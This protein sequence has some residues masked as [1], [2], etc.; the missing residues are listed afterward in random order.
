LNKKQLQQRL[1]RNTKKLD[2]NPK[3]LKCAEKKVTATQKKLL[4]TKEHCK[5][6]ASLALERRK[7]VRL[8]SLNA[9]IKEGAIR[10]ELGHAQLEL[11]YAQKELGHAQRRINDIT[12]DACGRIIEERASNTA[13][14]KS[15]ETSA[16]KC[17][18]K[19]LNRQAAS[20]NRQAAS[21]QKHHQKELNQQKMACDDAINQMQLTMKD[22][23]KKASSVRKR[24]AA[25]S[26]AANKRH[27]KESNK[28]K[29]LIQ[30]NLHDLSV[31][32]AKK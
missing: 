30:R 3:K 8:A 17:H 16:Q 1:D 9:E 21:A 26:I 11:G 23:E 14:A 32:A 29:R 20:A 31:S 6:L 15:D 24:Q 19:E 10:K 13:Q 22:N 18:Q 28:S 12:A 4:T 7:D 2:R 5:Q 25:K 27:K